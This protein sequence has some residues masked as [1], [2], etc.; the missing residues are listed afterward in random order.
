MIYNKEKEE[1]EAFAFFGFGCA[2]ASV[3]FFF[4]GLFII[5]APEDSFIEA[6]LS[7]LMLAPAAVYIISVITFIIIMLKINWKHIRKWR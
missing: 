5:F 4:I 2:L 7:W 6:L 1:T 3:Q